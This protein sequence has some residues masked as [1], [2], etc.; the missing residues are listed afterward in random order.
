MLVTE[1]IS[2]LT[3]QQLKNSYSKCK[4]K[5]KQISKSDKLENLILNQYNENGTK[6]YEDNI[7]ILESNLK[8]LIR[9]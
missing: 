3:R 2:Q 6:I 5:I 7:K 8:K 1:S 4:R 9:Q